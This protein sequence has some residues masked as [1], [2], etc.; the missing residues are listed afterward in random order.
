MTSYASSYS[1]ATGRNLQLAIIP[2][3]KTN[4]TEFINDLE[5]VV[6]PFLP[7]P[8]FL[9]IDWNVVDDTAQNYI[10]NKPVV[11]SLD[12]VDVAT[13][14]AQ[15]AADQANAAL[16]LLLAYKPPTGGNSNSNTTKDIV[17]GLVSGLIGA[18]VGAALAALALQ[19]L[20]GLIPGLLGG[21]IGSLFDDIGKG[22]EDMVD[23]LTDSADNANK[24]EELNIQP[25]WHGLSADL[26]Q[27]LNQPDIDT[28]LRVNSRVS[29]TTG[30]NALGKVT[31]IA[32][33]DL[34]L[35]Q[36]VYLN[37]NSSIGFIPSSITREAASITVGVPNDGSIF[38]NK[39]AL[40]IKGTNTYTSGTNP[41]LYL[42]QDVVIPGTLSVPY[43]S[44]LTTLDLGPTNATSALEYTPNGLTITGQTAISGITQPNTAGPSPA[45][46][47]KLVKNVE[48][49]GDLIVDGNLLVKGNAEIAG[50]SASAGF[51]QGYTTLPGG[52]IM[53]FGAFSYKPGF[54][55]TQMDIIFP[56]AYKQVC[57]S[58]VIQQNDPGWNFA[59]TGGSDYSTI[60]SSV[61]T[62]DIGV[63]NTSITKATLMIKSSAT[64]FP[65]YSLTGYFMAMGI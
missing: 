31:E 16:K 22:L 15:F 50:T 30:S 59:S 45:P 41:L 27:I 10:R 51:Y 26:G 43:I 36:D 23:G 25:D 29:R 48:V 28:V 13:Q 53:N 33:T 57:Y 56:K 47:I 24:L 11:P 5:Q 54:L 12:E 1:N 7:G 40:I 46:F 63:I 6:S 42:D 52:F 38:S 8:P 19:G 64:Y 62:T 58:C 4:L 35:G 14:R 34:L 20:K 44:T 21:T 3:N 55:P 37:T 17:I 49:T 2:N 61:P 32:S 18:A 60:T 65:S 9:Q 39:P